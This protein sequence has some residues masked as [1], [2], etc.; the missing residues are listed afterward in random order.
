MRVWVV[1]LALS[2][3]ITLALSAGQASARGPLDGSW[4]GHWTR[5]GAVLAVTHHFASSA[6]HYEGKVDAAQIRVKGWPFRE[7]KWDPPRVTWEI[8]WDDERVTRFDGELRGRVLRGRFDEKDA[9]G[10]FLL[11]KG[12]S[13]AKIVAEQ[14]VVFEN[15]PA[16]LE[17][18]VLA[19]RGRGPHPAIV[20]VPGSGPGPRSSFRTIA[21][22]YVA[23]GFVT[24]TYDKRSDWQSASLEQLAGDAAAAIALLSK[25]SD[26]APGRI[27]ID[28]AS[29]GGAIAP[30][31]A[32]QVGNLAFLIGTGAP[33]VPFR[34]SETY[35]F[36]NLLGVA[37]M[38]PS[39]A[40]VA[41]AYVRAIVGAL[42]DGEPRER[43]DALY[44]QVKGQPW[45]LEPPTDEHYIWQFSKRIAPYDPANEWRKLVVPALLVYGEEDERVPVRR[46]ASRIAQAYFE[47]RGTALQVMVFPKAD[48]ALRVGL[49]PMRQA[50][51]PGAAF[52]WGTSAPGYPSRVV[53]WASTIVGLPKS[54]TR[55]CAE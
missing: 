47:G 29:Q 15:G 50:P 46:S 10:T 36:E 17:G 4:T 43:L 9:A 3:A 22:C 12:S 32:N 44:L 8:E 27:G 37:D 51:V 41:R 21:E 55:V 48:H 18:T 45:A 53:D 49:L 16:R 11:R 39:E 5:D 33:G 23:R 42:F 19:P 2:L 25:R 6:T 24:L 28:G 35:S 13:P 54:R 14:T 26:V 20:F 40:R 38:S 52:S 1:L 34:A 30:L 7:V 31:I